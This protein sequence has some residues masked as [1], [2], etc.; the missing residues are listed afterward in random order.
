VGLFSKISPKRI[1][2]K[3][4]SAFTCMVFLLLL[5]GII[6]MKNVMNTSAMFES[7]LLAIRDLNSF[8]DE[9]NLLRLKMFEFLGT[10][11]PDKMESLTEEMNSAG[12]KAG[13]AL[14]SGKFHLDK[15]TDIFAKSMEEHKE[16]LQLHNDFQTKKAYRLIYGDSQKSFGQ[17]RAV[18]EEIMDD[19][20]NRMELERKKRSSRTMLIAVCGVAAGLLILLIGSLFIVRSVVAPLTRI[21]NALNTLSGKILSISDQMAAESRELAEDTNR[22]A[23]SVETSSASLEEMTAMSRKIS[24]MTVK[25]GTLMN[26]NI[27]KS[28]RS[29]KSLTQVTCEMIQ[30]EADSGQM[31][32]IMTNIDEIAFQTKL[33]SL[34]AAIEAAHA[35]EAGVGFAVVAD[36]VRSLARRA[37]ES[38]KNTQQLL[39][40]TLQKVSRATGLIKNVDSDFKAIMKSAISMGNMTDGVSEAIGEHVAGIDQVS[41]SA[42]EIESITQKIAGSSQ[43]LAASSEELSAYAGDLKSFVADLMNIVGQ[44]M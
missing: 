15:I 32:Q 9:V 20:E 12:N 42:S 27:A 29:S 1:E 8:N 33:L 41:M 24:E 25:A 21:R 5:E 6:S 7:H 38:A 17:I 2:S 26:E 31:S 14:E 16:I 34:N 22:S 39:N 28:D 23:A 4:I 35:G 36:E 13:A 11:N 43:E 10:Y 3:L 40:T 37:T 44:R 30:I 19:M 18:I